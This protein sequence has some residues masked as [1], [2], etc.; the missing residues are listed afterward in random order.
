MT[1]LPSHITGGDML[2][3]I[4]GGKLYHLHPNLQDWIK[5]HFFCQSIIDSG[6]RKFCKNCAH[7]KV[8]ISGYTMT[9]FYQ[10]GRSSD[11]VDS[12][13]GNA[14]TIYCETE[15]NTGECGPTA[16]FFTP[17]QEPAPAV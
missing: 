7:Y 16:R 17:K 11:R 2:T 1:T 4:C 15:R 12:V 5:T 3:C 9:T 8:E 13:N 10:C 14:Q 6:E